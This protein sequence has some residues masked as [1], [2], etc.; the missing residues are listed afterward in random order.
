MNN[1]FFGASRARSNI[2]IGGEKWGSYTNF[3]FES[4]APGI[5]SSGYNVHIFA[6]FEALDSRQNMLNVLEPFE[7]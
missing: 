1:I 6:I 5:V 4:V 3:H 2:L 7:G